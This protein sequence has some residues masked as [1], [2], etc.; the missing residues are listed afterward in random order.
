MQYTI[1]GNTITSYL[2]FHALRPEIEL[3]HRQQKIQDLEQKCY[4]TVKYIEDE[5]VVINEP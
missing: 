4:M 3:A 1:K 2:K 5:N